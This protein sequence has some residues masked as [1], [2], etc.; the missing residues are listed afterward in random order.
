MR[1]TGELA[2]PVLLILPFLEETREQ[3]ERCNIL[4]LDNTQTACECEEQEFG[5]LPVPPDINFV[6]DLPGHYTLPP[7]VVN[8]PLK[9]EYRRGRYAL[10]LLCQIM[11]LLCLGIQMK[12]AERTCFLCFS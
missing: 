8:K 6:L 11:V 5:K 4:G 1:E 10:P 3:D 7:K 2:R 9:G 12:P